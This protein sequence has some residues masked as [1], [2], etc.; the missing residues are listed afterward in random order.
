[1]RPSA[2]RRRIDRSERTT[3]RLYGR[4]GGYR[5]I[6]AATRTIDIR[7]EVPGPR[8]R[9]ILARKELVVADALTVTLPV[10]VEEARGATFTDVDGNTFVDF[11]GGVGCLAVGHAHPRVLA[12][13]EEQAR[14]FT[15][16]DFTVVPYEVYVA[17]A[18]RICALAPFAGPAKAAFFN[19]GTE[20]V[21]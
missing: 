14:R 20:A 19:A 13:I 21:E 1:M 4:V 16:T 9:E 17:L 6:V 11:A 15:H 2:R 8:S 5:G 12:A 7:T 10:V 18:E 3:R